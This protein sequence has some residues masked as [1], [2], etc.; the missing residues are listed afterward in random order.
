MGTKI[1][2]L[3]LLL[4]GFSLLLCSC[5]SGSTIDI[6]ENV[7]TFDPENNFQVSKIV[8]DDVSRLGL[9]RSKQWYW[10]TPEGWTVIDA[11]QFR[12]VNLT[13]GENGEGECY[14]TQL[15]PGSALAN[16]NRWR[17]Q[18]GAENI[19]ESDLNDLPTISLMGFPAR[20]VSVD[21]TF[22]ARGAAP[23]DNYRLLGAIISTPNVI[24]TVKMTGPKELLVANEAK[25]KSFCASLDYR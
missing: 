22:G 3:S 23:K 14:V 15:G 24:I 7:I 19:S 25:L 18:M 13:L 2:R 21:G 12:D 1:F 4:A 16:I 17:G 10:D 8:E 6:S 20:Y 9:V 5:D 11:K